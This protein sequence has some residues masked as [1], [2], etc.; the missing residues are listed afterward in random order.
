[1]I[2][3]QKNLIDRF[4]DFYYGY[5]ILK[6][7]VFKLRFENGYPNRDYEE[8]W[9]KFLSE[10]D[11]EG[12]L[13]E[14]LS[15]MKNEI[16]G[17]VI[18]II[19]TME[20]ASY[21]ALIH[22]NHP[23][24]TLGFVKDADLWNLWLEFGIYRYVREF[25]AEVL[26]IGKGDKIIDFGC[27]S[28]SPQ[29]FA[30]LVGNSGY[31]SGIDY[32]K[33][34][35]KIAESNCKESGTCDRINLRQAYF[36]TK[37]EF[38]REY[39]IVILSAVLEYASELKLVIRNALSAIK[40]EGRLIIFSELFTDFEPEREELMNLYY[41]LVPNFRKFPSVSEI[42]NE[43]DRIGVLYKIKNYG[44]HILVVDVFE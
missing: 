30:E 15:Y 36:D 39:D 1:M 11:Y 44:K 19:D 40:F 7:Y 33:P 12:L 17:R 9:R 20:K 10:A 32:S 3:I 2:Q 34:L 31:Y 5:L 38:K 13:D 37:L 6:S 35:L 4:M 43:L 26:S 28:A 14:A 22:P 42:Q 29:F 24:I 25:V 18:D 16:D 27:G 8:K 23:N 21:Y 41:S